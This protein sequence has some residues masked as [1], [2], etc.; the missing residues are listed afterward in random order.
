MTVL[1]GEKGSVLEV[2][3]DDETIHTCDKKL[4]SRKLSK[5]EYAS[6]EEF[7]EQFFELEYKVAFAFSL[8]KIALKSFHSQELK[9]LL[10][11]RLIR[12]V[13]IQRLL[14]YFSE[15]KWLQDD[16]WL[17]FFVDKL[18]K[19]GK[20]A[21]EIFHKAKARGIAKTALVPFFQNK[22]KVKEA[23]LLLIT[24]RYPQLLDKKSTLS[25]RQKAVA[26]L[27]RKGFPVDEI[28]SA[29]SECT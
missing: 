20:S 17:E 4:F 6:K 23:L 28:R 19:Q 29:L 7:E 13:T 24:K 3:C 22:N 26:A 15:K 14:T 11:K 25:I 2:I 8:R 1:V 27:I 10:Q 9:Q 21:H 18:I 12:E 16:E 5:R